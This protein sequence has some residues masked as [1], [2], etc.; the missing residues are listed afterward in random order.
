[1]KDLLQQ[2]ITGAPVTVRI[3]GLDRTLAYPLYAV[4]LYKQLT[5][6]SLFVK[7]S[8]EKIDLATDPDRWLKCLWAGLH[9]FNREWSVPF[10]L[11]ELAVLID[12]SNAGEISI[13][14]AR[15]LTQ[16]MPKARKE[17]ARKEDADPNAE[18]PG[19]PALIAVDPVSSV[20][21]PASTGSTPEPV[22]VSVLAGPSS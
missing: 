10:P 12:F 18:A 13:A 21:S 1:M 4:I 14:M 3:R 15:A 6:D 8:F 16:S 20:T 19:S 2:E 11:E 9:V 7:A 22:D 17:D 5:G